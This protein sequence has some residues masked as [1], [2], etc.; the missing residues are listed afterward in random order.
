MIYGIEGAAALN[1]DIVINEGANSYICKLDPTKAAKETNVPIEQR[2]CWSI[3][4]YEQI[5]T[6]DDRIILNTKYP[7]GSVKYDFQI[8]EY[9]N[10]NYEF[11]L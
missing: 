10:Y 6:E 8:S 4:F 5:K 3:I 7:Y 11:R 9:K 1:A 2:H